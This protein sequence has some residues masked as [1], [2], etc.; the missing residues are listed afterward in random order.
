MRGNKGLKE[1]KNK[2]IKSTSDILES[3]AMIRD[4]IS[5]NGNLHEKVEVLKNQIQKQE[6]ETFGLMQENQVLRE[7]WE[8]ASYSLSTGNQP[9][10]EET[11]SAAYERMLKEQRGM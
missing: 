8:M 5:A 7:R 6:K 9:T 4:L 11:P 3:I 1:P 10:P 2:Q